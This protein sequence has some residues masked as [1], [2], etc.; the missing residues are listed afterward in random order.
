[1]YYVNGVYRAYY[2]KFK[3]QMLEDTLDL[4]RLAVDMDQEEWFNELCKRY[5]EL[6]ED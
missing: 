6:L 3:A 1:M 4:M 2:G 5:N